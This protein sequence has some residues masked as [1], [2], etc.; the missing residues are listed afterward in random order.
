MSKS[1]PAKRNVPATFCVL[2]IMFLCPF[3]SNGQTTSSDTSV[4]SLP[5]KVSQTYQVADSIEY[6]FERPKLFHFA[7]AIP[8]DMVRYCKITFKKD[9]LLNVAYM[10]AGTAALVVVDQPITDASKDFGKNIGIAP[11]N[12][13]KTFL[14]LSFN[15]GSTKIPLPLNGPW[16]LNSS[17]YYIGDGITHFSIAGGF[18]AFGLIKKDYRALQTASQLMESILS[19]GIAVQLLKHVTGRESPYTTTTPGGLWRVFPNQ[20][21]YSKHVPHYDAFPS[22]HI[23]TAMATVTVI[24]LNYPEYKWIR[25]VGYTA[26]GLLTFAMLNNGVHWASDYPL[27]IALGYSFAKIAVNAGRKV[28]EKDKKNTSFLNYNWIKSAKL[29]PAYSGRTLG[30]QVSWTF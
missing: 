2:F 22:G 6:E 20:I 11:T 30:C 5:V 25:P 27:G 16:D 9:N 24:A 15:I 28:V 14:D 18:W 7:K 3:F 29:T 4:K 17:L 12:T 23:A 26:M 1:H 10:I 21:E 13:Q 19:T 8:G